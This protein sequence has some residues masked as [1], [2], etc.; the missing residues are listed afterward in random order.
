[1]K[2]SL[3]HLQEFTAPGTPPLDEVG[4][5]AIGGVAFRIPS[6]G[7]NFLQ[8]VASELTGWDH[9]SILEYYPLKH[10]HKDRKTNKLEIEWRPRVPTQD[11][12]HKIRSMFFADEERVMQIIPPAFLFQDRDQRKAIHL[13]SPQGEEWP[14]TWP[15]ALTKGNI[16]T[17][18][19]FKN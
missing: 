9:L 3:V 7:E 14:A 2:T 1:M 8:V 10:D 19:G 5:E 16:I 13:W 17:P 18:P 15:W 11:A 4:I 12:I 6:L